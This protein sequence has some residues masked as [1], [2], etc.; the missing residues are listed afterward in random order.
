MAAHGLMGLVAADANSLSPGHLPEV[1]TVAASDSTDTRWVNS[2]YDSSVDLYAPGVDIRSA[3]YLNVN[4]SWVASGTSMACPFVS[5]AV[6][7]F[8]QSNPLATP[9]VVR[10]PQGTDQLRPGSSCCLAR[11]CLPHVG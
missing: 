9:Q 3:Y 4:A 8:L 1:I 11:P 7:L 5:G 2:N 10:S 6:A